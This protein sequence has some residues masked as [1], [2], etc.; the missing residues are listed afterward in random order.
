MLTLRCA[1]QTRAFLSP[2]SA[3]TAALNLFSTAATHSPAAYPFSPSSNSSSSTTSNGSL[4]EIN[5]EDLVYYFREW[6]MSRKKPLFDRIF[7]ILRTQDDSS[8][9]SALSR[10]NLG[11]SES[12]V[13]DVLNYEKKD[14]LSCLKFFDWAGR[15]PGFHHTR[16]TFNCIFRILSKAKLMNLML[17]FLQNYMKQRYVHKVRYY[18]ILVIGY[19]AA[20]KSE[21]AL[22]LFGRMRFQGVDLDAFAYHVLMNSLVEEGYFDVVETVA[23]EI[24][25]RGFQNEVTHSIM[26]KSFYKQKEL[27]RGEEYLRGLVEDNGAQLSGI[28]VA[29]FVAALCKDNQFER[30]ALLIEEFRKMNLVSMEH[31][32][33]VWIRDLVKAGK[34]DCVL[35]FLKD[36]QAV[37]DYVPD[38]FR[39]NTL[40]CRLLRENRLE[41]VHDLLVDMKQREILPDDVTMNAVLCF[42][43]KAG[44]MDIAMDLYNSRIE[45]GLSVNCMAYNYLI[46]T[47]LGDVSVDEAYRLLRNSM[48]QGYFPGQKTFSIVAD[49]L[50]REGKFDKMKEL[51]IFML[52]QNIMP[53]NFTYDKFIS[54]LCR[55]SR[56]EEGY[57]LHDL[58][59]RLNKASRKSTYLNLISGFIKSSRGDIAARL[60]I[61]MQEKGYIP[62][63]RL[64]RE[65]ICCLCKTDNPEKQFFGL[66]EMQLAR[67]K[68]SAS[69]VYNFFIDGAGH[70][71]K[72]ELAMQVYEMMRRSG[73]VPSFN[74]DILLLQ[75]Y[76]KS[77]RIAQAL[78]L[79]RDLS[80]RWRKRKL[81]QTMVVGLCKVQKPE[82]ASQILEDMKT[83]RR[84]PSIECYEELIKLYCALGQYHKAVELVNEMTQ[85][86]RPVSSFIGNVFLLHALR[87]RKLYYAWVSL[88][89][90]QNLTPASWMLGHLIGVFSGCLEGFDDDD[91]VEKLVQQ[92]FRV[93]IYTNNMLLR[94]LSMKGIDFAC[95]F[96]DR[97][98]EKGYEPNRWTYDI[99]VH[100]LAK[101]GRN[102]EARIWMEDMLRKGY[103][104]TEVTQNII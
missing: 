67:S 87:S 77:E 71:R 19:A 68:S 100:G 22:G 42:L 28:A 59:N 82:H 65:V 85:T 7:E 37:E 64:V 29:T 101:E 11:L 70:A 41:E 10:F 83:N 13:L 43:C 63:R 51:V 12:L 96:F 90:K 74:S 104:L 60:L 34:L 6:F 86:G 40:I 20:G 50:C 78:Q 17:D 21:T 91:E 56:V 79:F 73:L 49:A 94:R 88:S 66:L 9:D 5:H 89:Q 47:L 81:W 15:Q 44:M 14:V 2:P 53:N 8:F 69:V 52:D 4:S 54:A 61:E 76:L 25:I 39:Y 99:I 55:A 33:G 46:N 103:H 62:T 75:S 72:P 80:T 1:R 97:F 45:F 98:R 57:L 3:S 18:N 102:S 30:A 16:A 84:T 32:Y 31:A 23:K 95:K 38:V 48:E 24:R 92:C 35:E 27:E 36:K 26:M 58:L 93:D